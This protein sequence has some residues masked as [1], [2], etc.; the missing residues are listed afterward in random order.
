[1]NKIVV[2]K[3]NDQYCCSY[4]GGINEDIAVFGASRA[5]HH[6][7]PQV[8]Q[9]SLG[10]K[11]MNYGCDGQNIYNHYA[12]LS[13]RINNSS[14]KPKLVML[15]IASIDISDT[16]GHNTD[17]LSVLNPFYDL[18]NDVKQVLGLK[19][20]TYNYGLRMSKLFK[21][22]SYLSVVV[23]CFFGIEEGVYKNQ[24]Y[25]PLYGQWKKN[26]EII[27]EDKDPNMDG[28]KRSYLIRF[29]E[30]CKD[31]DIPIIILN[32]P[33]FVI[34]DVNRTWWKEVVNIAQDYDVPCW[35]YEQSEM[36]ISSPEV[37]NEPYHLNDKGAKLY[38]V[39]VASRI[40]EE[41]LCATE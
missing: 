33:H 30:L 32:S 2:E 9:D 27:K 1:M 36:F 39:V 17:K 41:Y 40:K 11:L 28:T 22:N 8:F 20:K 18:N 29:I 34:Y 13:M 6:Y 26:I 19:G 16:P 23:K 24:G 31:N 37:F 35:D 14:E 15:E 12:M 38:S 4:R 3:L 25:E 5:A 7:V 10:Y 21:Y